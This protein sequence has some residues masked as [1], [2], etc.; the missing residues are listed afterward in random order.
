MSLPKHID[1]MRMREEEIFSLL[2]FTS[3]KT[4]GF[5]DPKLITIGGYALRAYIPLHFGH[6]AINETNSEGLVRAHVCPHFKH[7]IFI[8]I[9]LSIP[10]I[11]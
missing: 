8:T 5:S 2:E 10:L 9:T 1:I 4:Q 3:Q 11:Q 7:F 6:L